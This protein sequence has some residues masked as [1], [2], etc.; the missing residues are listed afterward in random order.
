MDNMNL[1]ISEMLFVLQISQS[2]NIAKKWFCIQNFHL[3]ISFQK[4]EKNSWEICFLVPE[5]S[6]KYKRSIFFRRPVDQHRCSLES[7]DTG[8]GGEIVKASYLLTESLRVSHKKCI[9]T[10]FDCL[11]NISATEKQIY[12]PF[13]SSQNWDP[14][15]NSEYKI[16]SEQF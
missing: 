5:I 12:K 2:L 9:I 11:W 15:V 8:W 7:T 16:I 14:S 1:S 13:F 4:K 6:N 3:D 10:I